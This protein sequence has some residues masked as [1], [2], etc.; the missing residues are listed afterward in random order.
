MEVL[1]GKE[2]YYWSLAVLR[3]LKPIYMLKQATLLL[4][5]LQV[6]KDEGKKLAKEMKIEDVGKLKEYDARLKLT[7][8]SNQQNLPN[9][10]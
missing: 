9:L 2:H 6:T 5:P 8:Q 1:Q 3:L 4:E 7:S 10:S